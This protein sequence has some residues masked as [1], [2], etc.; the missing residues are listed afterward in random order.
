MA[1]SEQRPRFSR[2]A[3][4]LHVD[5]LERLAGRGDIEQALAMGER[6]IKQHAGEEDVVAHARIVL[7]RLYL[8]KNMKYKGVDM[9]NR[10][11]TS[12]QNFAELWPGWLLLAEVYEHDHAYREAL[13]IYQKIVRECPRSLEIGWM[14]RVRA[15]ALEDRLGSNAS[16]ENLVKTVIDA[17]HPFA[18]PRAIARYLAGDL[19]ADSLSRVWRAARPGDHGYLYFLAREDM[20]SGRMVAA[21]RRLRALRDSSPA[22]SW[23]R[24]RYASLLNLWE[25]SQTAAARP[26]AQGK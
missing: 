12:S 9:L 16:A 8:G 4:R 2:L 21:R 13:S 1:I 25:T 19:S 17:D 22:H 6:I 20:S 18:L 15:A 5:I 24:V 26:A 14:A 7:G 23:D 10:A 11:T 3:G